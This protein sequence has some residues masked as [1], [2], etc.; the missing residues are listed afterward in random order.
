MTDSVR[1][2]FAPSPTGTLHIGG[3]R[4][5][6]FNWLFARH[7]NGVFILR[8]EDTDRT[9]FDENALNDIYTAL[10][11]LGIPPDEGP[12]SGGDY[13]PYVQSERVA[14]YREHAERLCREGHAY[15]CFCTPER[16]EKLREEQRANSMTSGYDGKCR[17]LSEDERAAAFAADTPYVIRCAMP[18]EG[19]LTFHD[20]V[21]GT[22]TY[23]CAQQDD[24]VLLK[25]DGFPT[26]HLANVVDDHLMAISH[27][28][29]GEEWI[30]STPKHIQLYTAF[31]WTAPTFVHL[32]I[33][34]APGG[35]KLS[36]RH[37]ATALSAYRALGYLPEALMNFLSLLGWSYAADEEIAT[38]EEL[39][40][41]FD[42]HG[43]N[44]SPAQ[45]DHEKLDWM[46][47]AYIRAMSCDELGVRVKPFLVAAD[48]W[49]ETCT[50]AYL[51]AVLSLLQPRL[52]R[53]TDSVEKHAYFFCEIP[54]YDDAVVK[55]FL[56][57]E[58]VENH[59][60]ALHSLFDA[61]EE[62]DFTVET[63]EDIVT[64]YL[65]ESGQ[66]LKKV[67]HPLRVAV[68]GTAMSPGI[69]ETLATI[70][71][72]RV[73]ARISYALTHLVTPVDT[74]S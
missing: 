34:L 61:C 42:I 26:Y 43:I 72:R 56:Q 15:P 51:H 44:A 41:A 54:V 13:G 49:N 12:R 35:G 20:G 6:L 66:S 47:G 33:I 50:D 9:R 10:D 68:T 8:I 4:T 18:R 11:W 53:L 16:L 22:I 17:S 38:A 21:R 30:P 45:F 64:T 62:Q 37:G 3:A 74:T 32:P 67:V 24:F 2:R 23:P 71:R 52:E 40:R 29:R 59:L 28:M 55:K 65:A 36:K 1:V 7:H 39:I 57:K 60:S 25:T 5:A 27:V 73:L 14:L 70:G 46:N 19:S 63:L 31:G 58:G 69:Y 48:L